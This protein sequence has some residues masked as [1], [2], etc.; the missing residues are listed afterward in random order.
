M[1]KLV[2]L[3]VACCAPLPITRAGP[4]QYSFAEIMGPPA[5]YLLWFAYDIGPQGQVVGRVYNLNV[6]PPLHRGFVWQGGAMTLLDG[7]G[8]EPI[9]EARCIDDNGVPRVRA[10]STEALIHSAAHG[11]FSGD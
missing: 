4:P 8:A 3:I 1:K 10:Q 7:P 2:H 11:R 5:G 6:S 9:T